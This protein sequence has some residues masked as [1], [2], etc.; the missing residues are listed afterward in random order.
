[1]KLA[2]EYKDKFNQEIAPYIATLGYNE[3][4]TISDPNFKIIS[5]LDFSDFSLT[6]LHLKTNIEHIRFKNCRFHNLI[7]EGLMIDMEFIECRFNDI[8]LHEVSMGMSFINCSIGKFTIND[9]DVINS[10]LVKNTNN[11]DKAIGTLE[12][13]N[14]TF[15]NNFTITNIEIHFLTICNTDFEKI[16]DFNNVTVH[17]ECSFEE[18]KF[19][20]LA[21]FDKCTFDANVLFKYVVFES[22]SH[23]RGSTFNNG[24]D[25]DYSSSKQEMNFHGI[26]GLE[27]Y[28]SK[29]NTSQETYRIIKNQ[30]EK[31]GNR[32]ESNKYHSLELKKRQNNLPFCS[33]DY[34]V[35]FFHWISSNHSK[36]WLFALFWILVVSFCTNLFVG[37]NTIDF[38]FDGWDNI[39]KYINILSKLEDFNNSYLVMTLNKLSLGYLY[40]QF[41]TAVRKDTRK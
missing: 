34:V 6:D 9:S 12:I 36:N 22:F 30:F 29:N 16:L 11:K 32:I 38:S 39:F 8:K 17:E 35:L 1:M 4:F 21:L 3:Q 2:S 37:N 31:L 10:I 13:D 14:C 18:I 33:L 26:E 5:N 25:L 24:L 27:K 23:F 28:S 40:Y 19:K 7:N 41:L 20:D 15:K